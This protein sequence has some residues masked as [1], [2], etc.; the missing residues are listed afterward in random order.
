M[1]HLA[2]ELSASRALQ[3]V[4]MNRYHDRWW[5]LQALY[6]HELDQVMA[7]PV[8]SWGHCVELAEVAWQYSTKAHFD[9]PP[10]VSS[11][12][13]GSDAARQQRQKLHPE[14]AVQPWDDLK[15]RPPTITRVVP[16]LVE[17]V[18]TM[19]AGQR[20]DPHMD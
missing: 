20:F 3:H 15:S 5:D 11:H 18:L 10:Y 9:V 1:R 17:A 2:R 19:G 7:R 12:L 8:T 14:M 4:D 13:E 16:A 6:H